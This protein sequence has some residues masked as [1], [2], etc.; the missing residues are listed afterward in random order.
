MES[1]RSPVNELPVGERVGVHDAPQGVSED[2]RVVP[3]VEPPFQFFEV[4]VQMLRTDLVE[5][6]DDGA[7]QQAPDAF[8]AVRVHIA[9]DP[10]LDGVTD[11]AVPRVG[12]PDAEVRQQLI[13]VDRLGLVLDVPVNESVERRLADVG[14]ALKPYL[15]AAL[16][17]SRNP[18]LSDPVPGSHA[19]PA[20]ADQGFVYFNDSEQC[21]PGQAV[22]AHR[23]A[24]TVAQVPRGLVG[25]TERPLELVG[26]HALSRFQQQVDRYE[27]L[28]KLKVGIVHDGSGRDAELVVAPEVTNDVLMLGMDYMNE[29]FSESDLRAI[30]YFEGR[31]QAGLAAARCT[32]LGSVQETIQ[33]ASEARRSYAAEAKEA[34]I[35]ARE[36]GQ[37]EVDAQARREAWADEWVRVGEALDVHL[38]AFQIAKEYADQLSVENL[39][40]GEARGQLLRLERAIDGGEADAQALLA[41]FATPPDGLPAEVWAVIDQARQMTERRLAGFAEA[42]EALREFESFVDEV[43]GEKSP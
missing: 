28:P 14:D 1:L 6:A 42:R 26:A 7:L 20:A 16:D 33:A 32:E 41:L 18:G 36:L 11:D 31:I 22:V 34:Q 38:A 12:I 23:R 13:G 10:F 4:A 2:V 19:A 9:D 3:V 35:L 40:A 21:R 17:R 8:D 25:H 27:P 43:D 39:V 30:E 37:D 29:E 24:D 5:R 15:A